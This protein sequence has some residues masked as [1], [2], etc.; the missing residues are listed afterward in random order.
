[1]SFSEKFAKTYKQLLPSPLSIAILLTFLTYVLA[2][3]FTKP[4]DISYSSYSIDL[5]GSWEEGLWKEG[6][7]GLYFTF[8]M[9]LMLVLGHIMALSKPV[10]NLINTLTQPC[11]NTANTALIVTL[12]TILVSLFNWGL[13]LIFGAILA[14]K[15]GEKFHQE[16]KPLN[17]PLIGAAAYSGLM[18]WHGGLSGSAPIKAAEQNNLHDMV[19]GMNLNTQHVPSSIDLGETIFS[20]MN[21]VVSILLI[22]LLPAMMYYFGKKERS[23][24]HLPKPTKIQDH[25]VVKAEGAERIDQSKIFVY[26]IGTVILAYAFYKAF[27]SQGQFNLKFLTPNFINFFLLG[28]GL[29]LHKSINNFVKAADEAISGAT[30]ILI[31]FPLYFGILGLMVGS[32]LIGQ[33]SDW[34]VSISNESSFPIYSFFSAG[35]VNVFVPSGGGQW[36]VQGPII[37]ASAQELGVSYPKAI[38]ALAYG[39]QL[40][41]MIQPFWALPLLGIT[42]LKAKDILPYTLLQFLA[43]TFIFLAGLILF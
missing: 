13:G 4:V 38:M 24:Q 7:G 16:N 20:T 3:F 30:G 9:M 11:T 25:D 33:I 15:I 31:Q 8:Q 18:V 43:G 29:I 27:L 34:F 37:I 2:L 36:A 28:S 35:L 1:M 32:G 21:I 23:Y 6:N 5:L 39:D 19:S 14:R 12:S 26:L 42:G 22:V 10:S 40:T 17:Y 41:N